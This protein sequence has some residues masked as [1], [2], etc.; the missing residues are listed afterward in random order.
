[1]RRG[2]SVSGTMF[3]DVFLGFLFFFVLMAVRKGS[4]DVGAGGFG[5]RFELVGL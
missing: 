1:M 4:A 3:L 2:V 5:G